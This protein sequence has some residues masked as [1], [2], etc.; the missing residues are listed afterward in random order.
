MRKSTYSFL[1]L[2]K[3]HHIVAKNKT[4]VLTNNT[5]DQPHPGVRQTQTADLQTGR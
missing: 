3:K 4:A 1:I 5:S 2:S